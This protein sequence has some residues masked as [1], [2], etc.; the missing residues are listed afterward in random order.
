MN[1]SKPSKSAL[2]RQF[3]E[4]QL[5]G[6][7]LIELTDAQL[8]DIVPDPRLIDAVRQARSTTSHGALRRQK[9][10]IGKLMRGI[11]AEPIKLAIEALNRHPQEDKRI[12]REA[13][14]WRTRLCSDAEGALA[15]FRSQTGSDSL[16]L[17]RLVAEHAAATLEAARKALSRR[18]FREVHRELAAR[19]ESRVR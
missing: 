4:L 14:T 17:E 5:L 19:M 10:L 1:E 18:I 16:V 2:K 3:T 12:F 15:E 13:E 8:T 9:Q 11:D 7:S 6:E